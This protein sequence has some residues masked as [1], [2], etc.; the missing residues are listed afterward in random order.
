MADLSTVPEQ[1]GEIVR[2]LLTLG[3]GAGQSATN[4]RGTQSYVTQTGDTSFDQ[5]EGMEL[6]GIHPYS[7]SSSH[8]IR[9]RQHGGGFNTWR[10]IPGNDA[11]EVRIAISTDGDTVRTGVQG[12]IGGGYWNWELPGLS[13]L[14]RVGAGATIAIVINVPGAP[15]PPPTP[16]T[17]DTAAAVASGAPLVSVS[18]EHVETAVRDTEAAITSGAPG[19]SA[20]AQHDTSEVIDTEASIE[21]GAPS[22][23]AD[24]ARTEAGQADIAATA[25]AGAPALTAGV[26]TVG[27][28]PPSDVGGDVAAVVVPVPS[29]TNLQ[30]CRMLAGAWMPRRDRVAVMPLLCVVEG[31]AEDLVWAICREICKQLPYYTYGLDC[32]PSDSAPTGTIGRAAGEHTRGAIVVSLDTSQR[33]P[34]FE[35]GSWEPSVSEVRLLVSQSTTTDFDDLELFISRRADL[36]RVL[37]RMTGGIGVP[38][39]G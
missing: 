39:R 12:S 1:D 7:P 35:Q 20:A 16:V 4:L 8:P 32:V 22:V 31:A 9:F 26:E 15:P 37:S 18:A 21:G 38:A 14:N 2:C 3:S 30:T 13:R 36:R 17:R 25:A 29:A 34:E 10:A 24:A 6:N 5:I 11:V 33:E 19:I 28:Q 27:V 23:A